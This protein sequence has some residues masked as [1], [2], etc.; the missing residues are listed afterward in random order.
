MLFFARTKIYNLGGTPSR[1]CVARMTPTKIEM[2]W[3]QPASV[4]SMASTGLRK[5]HGIR[6]W[7]QPAWHQVAL[8]TIYSTVQYTCHT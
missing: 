2:S 4:G 6:K 8:I 3:H 1:A 5:W 7:H